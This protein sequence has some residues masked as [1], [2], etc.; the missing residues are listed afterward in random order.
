MLGTSRPRDARSVATKTLTRRLLKT[1]MIRTR[2]VWSLSPWITSTCMPMRSFMLWANSS[3]ACLD[4]AKTSTC[5][6][7]I[8][9]SSRAASQGHFAS[10]VSRIS[11]V[12]ATVSAACPSLPIV[13]LTGLASRSW[14][15]RS[16]FGGKVAEKNN[17][18]RLGRTF[19]TSERN[20]CSK[21]MC[22]ILSASSR[23]RKVQRR[24]VQPFILTMSIMRPGVAITTSLP[25]LISLNCFCL[26]I[27]P[28]KLQIRRPTALHSFSPS[29]STWMASSLVGHT[30]RPMGPSS[31]PTAGCGQLCTTIGM[32]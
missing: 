14:D 27:P 5:P 10:S 25:A 23:T 16:I 28:A 3:A 9:A 11:A 15:M 13:I 6:F 24:R 19:C 2:S 29:F 32:R 30:A 26:D 7:R 22:S 12:C 4:L 31:R 18:W 17:V 8:M 1:S 20:W 21:P